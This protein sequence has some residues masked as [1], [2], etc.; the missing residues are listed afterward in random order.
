M[1]YQKESH[2]IHY[3]ENPIIDSLINYNTRIPSL[4]FRART[5]YTSPTKIDKILEK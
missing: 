5:T 3:L 2:Q 1:M 4:A